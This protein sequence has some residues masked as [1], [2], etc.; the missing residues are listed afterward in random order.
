MLQD[1]KMRTPIEHGLVRVDLDCR[2][3]ELHLKSEWRKQSHRWGDQEKYGRFR[4]RCCS[5]NLTGFIGAPDD[6]PWIIY[7]K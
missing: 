3:S 7:L 1:R 4:F 6:D 2:A 5:T